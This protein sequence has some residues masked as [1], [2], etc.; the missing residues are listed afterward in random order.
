MEKSENIKQISK[1]LQLFQ[2]KVEPIKKDASNPFFKSKYA[3]LSNTLDAI[4]MPLSECGLVFSQ[5]PDGNSLTT[6]VVHVESGE[7]FQSTYDLSPVKSDPQSIGSAITYARRYA[8]TSIL[9]LNIDDDDDGNMASGNYE[10]EWLNENSDAFIK[11]KIAIQNGT[12]TIL[13]VKRKY[14]L[15]KEIEQKLTK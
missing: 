10:K 15:S 4:Q 6:I 14:K 1:A 8:L 3:T 11:A 12:H 2:V 13:D 5:H 7:F 9:G